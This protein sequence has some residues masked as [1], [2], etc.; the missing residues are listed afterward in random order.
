VISPSARRPGRS[1]GAEQLPHGSSEP[2]PPRDASL[3]ID[4]KI[5]LVGS[6]LRPRGTAV[7]LGHTRPRESGRPA[8]ITT[9]WGEIGSAGVLTGREAPPQRKPR[10]RLTRPPSSAL[11]LERSWTTPGYD[12]VSPRPMVAGAPTSRLPHRPRLRSHARDGWPSLKIS[13][14]NTNTALRALPRRHR[15]S[16]FRA[17]PTPTRRVST[18]SSRGAQ[19][20]FEAIVRMASARPS[21]SEKLLGFRRRGDLSLA[22]RGRFW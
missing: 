21:K 1:F 8:Q 3:R 20:L 17:G 9:I 5:A 19:N 14:T 13:S 12:P 4:E 7:E 15:P 18:A 16:T 2:S 22:G 10:R 6:T 11:A